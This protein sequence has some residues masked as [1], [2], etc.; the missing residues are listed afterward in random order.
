LS[1]RSKE[2]K[3]A[4]PSSTVSSFEGKIDGATEEQEENLFELKVDHF[5]WK[6]GK[7][8]M[9]NGRE[10]IPLFSVKK[11]TYS[12]TMF[13]VDKSSKESKWLLDP[14][15]L[16]I[17]VPNLI[18]TLR[19]IYPN[20]LHS[21]KEI[22]QITGEFFDE[23]R[24]GLDLSYLVMSAV[25]DLKI[26]I[27][28]LIEGELQLIIQAYENANL[29]KAPRVEPTESVP[30]ED[31]AQDSLHVLLNSSPTTAFNMSPAPVLLFPHPSQNLGLNPIIQSVTPNPPS[32]A[33][34]EKC[35]WTRSFS[36]WI[37]FS[38]SERN[39]H[40]C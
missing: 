30:L 10:K 32:P 23:L 21:T 5:F 37:G 31:L 7:A 22:M 35:F 11:G 9:L 15:S 28:G 14:Q 3:F 40:H 17:G 12:L 19:G 24:P 26:E 18:W 16:R 36:D 34:G 33:I 39:H 8:Q 29:F 38:S 6:N 2:A 13:G 20:L 1:S 4:S 27:K 25:F